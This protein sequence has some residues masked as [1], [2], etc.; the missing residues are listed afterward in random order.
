MKFCVVVQKSLL[1]SRIVYIKI[2]MRK[3]PSPPIFS[4]KKKEGSKHIFEL[5][6]RG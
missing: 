4:L 1:S 6:T 5:L 2:W 3:T